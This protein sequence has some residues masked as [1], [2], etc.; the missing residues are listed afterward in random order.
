M[1]AKKA[2]KKK[3]KIMK[4]PKSLKTPTNIATRKLKESRNLT[5]CRHLIIAY[6]KQS[7]VTKVYTSSMARSCLSKSKQK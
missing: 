4:G 5:Y 6:A 1:R 2:T 7:T 3:N